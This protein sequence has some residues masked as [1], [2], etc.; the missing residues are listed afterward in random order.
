MNKLKSIQ[1]IRRKLK[2]GQPTIGGWMQIPHG[3]VAEIMG[4]ADYDWVAIDM[5]H[6]AIGVEQLPDLFRALELGNTLPLVRVAEGTAK[7]CKQALDAGAGGVIVPNVQSAAQL[8]AIRDACR[9]PPAGKRGVG[10]CRA[11]LFGRNFKEYAREAQDPFLVAMIEDLRA[12]QVLDT[13]LR[14]KGLDAILVGPYDLS[15]SAGCTG[16]F[17]HP[18]FR[19]ALAK[20]LKE[21]KRSGIPAGLHVVSP[22]PRELKKRIREG[23]RLIAY[24]IDAVLL[25]EA[26]RSRAQK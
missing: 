11:N 7:D 20:I 25:A 23:F 4:A 2:R 14:V 8:T 9:W 6:G 26:L 22:S 10:F 15:A 24:S 18:R 13:I 21:A 12:V 17:T 5:E 1:A 3:S 16:D 19:A